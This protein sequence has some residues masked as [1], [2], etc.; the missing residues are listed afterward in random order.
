[1]LSFVI[2]ENI[3]KE[4]QENMMEER[5]EDMIH[6]TLKSGGSIIEAKWNNQELI[7]ALM[8]S[9][10]SLGNVL[11]FHTNLVVAKVKIKFG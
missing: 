10:C 7:V 3:I 9:E 2:D 4:N 1:V 11:F 8:S 5:M 6:E